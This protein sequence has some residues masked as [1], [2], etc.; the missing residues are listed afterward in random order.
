[1]MIMTHNI[2]MK[3]ELNENF[4][5]EMFITELHGEMNVVTFCNIAASIVFLQFYSS[6]INHST[7]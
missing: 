7:V 4:E 1:M 6:T 5:D 2:Y 3:S